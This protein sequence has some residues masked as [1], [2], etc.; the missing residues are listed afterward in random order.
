[1]VTRLSQTDYP[2]EVCGLCVVGKHTQT[3][4]PKKTTWKAKD[5]LELVHTSICGAINPTSNG[6]K[7]ISLCFSM[8]LLEKVG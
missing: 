2:N 4:F 1:M 5:V 3:S 7:R 6:G 8:T